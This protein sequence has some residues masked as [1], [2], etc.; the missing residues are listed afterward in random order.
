MHS[1]HSFILFTLH[2]QETFAW[3]SNH[4]FI[5]PDDKTKKDTDKPEGIISK[6]FLVYICTQAHFLE[7]FI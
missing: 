2:I 6:S 7:T 4:T 1:A 3:N 5:A